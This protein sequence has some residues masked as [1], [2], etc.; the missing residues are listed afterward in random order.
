MKKNLKFAE[1]F[2]INHLRLIIFCFL[3]G[4]L[5]FMQSCEKKNEKIFFK[6]NHTPEIK[7]L[8]KRADFFFNSAENDSAYLY[9]NSAV[10]LCNP[11][12]DYAEDYVYALSRIAN[13]QRNNSDYFTSEQTLTKTLPYLKDL[14]NIEIINNV[15]SLIAYNYYYSFDYK[16]S[17]LYHLKALK[18]AQTSYSK[19]VILNDIIL[20]YLSQEKYK[21][22]AELLIPLVAKKIRH[23][24]DSR[25]TENTYSLLLDNLGY[26]YYKLGNPKALDCL[27]K[28]L[29][30]KL[31]QRDEYGLIGTYNTLSLF[32]SKTDPKL[33][34]MY[35]EKA[36]ASA[37]KVNAGI[38]KAN[39]LA[40]LIQNSEG[41]ELKKYS[42][43]FIKLVDS[44]L[45]ARQKAKNEFSRIKYDSGID[46]AE[47]LQLKTQKIKN[48]IQLERQ[49]KRNIISYIL[50]LFI[51]TLSLFLYCYLTLKGKKEKDTAILESE[52]RISKKL[53]DE[54][55]NEVYNILVFTENTDLKQEE[56]KE[57]LLNNL[58]TIY[59]RTRNI[60]KENSR[61]ITD[62]DY[63]ISLKEMIS[64]YKTP[65]VNII[66]NGFDLISWTEM[67]KNKKIILFR[68]LQ[69]LFAN[70]KKHSQATLVSVNFKNIKKNLTVTYNDNGIGATTRP[71]ILKNGLQN[72]ESR[73]KTIN[74]NIIF[75]NNSER[76]F[77]LTFSIPLKTR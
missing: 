6:H 9:F 38:Y 33:S 51:T 4:S 42:L 60:S 19:S 10:S 70:M 31:E 68:I 27:K 21:E 22:A 36:Y 30:I 44:F 52:M 1:S 28:S 5:F 45:I 65:D 72:V 37:C 41:D 46:K 71:L 50:I 12:A 56:N 17:V 77:R 57:H 32:Y 75:D 18:L 20:V 39:G 53:H 62:K 24:T 16:N 59:Y 73:I 43:D 47:N 76:G 63:D 3:S 34:K 48:E 23:E 69:E 74:G 54:L 58:D 26:C 40:V 25:K 49:K 35:A 64:G 14:K 11:K 66:L 15:Y 61:I 2:M 8:I 29:K 13:I 67:E 7:K 55:A